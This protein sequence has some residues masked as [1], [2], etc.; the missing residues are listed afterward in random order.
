MNNNMW[1]GS[2]GW[3]STGEVST[4]SNPVFS[5]HPEPRPLTK[6]DAYPSMTMSPMCDAT[7]PK[8]IDPWGED[9]RSSDPYVKL[10]RSEGPHKLTPIAGM[11]PP[12]CDT[13]PRPPLLQG[14]EA[15]D[16]FDPQPF[17]R[18]HCRDFS[19]RQRNPL[20]QGLSRP[21][22]QSGRLPPVTH[23]PPWQASKT[24]HLKFERSVSFLSTLKEMQQRDK[25]TG[26]RMDA[27]FHGYM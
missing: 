20:R 5:Y 2:P 10:L 16:P 23:P 26:G 21:G 11:P 8:R 3:G 12:R 1:W 14:E 13:C 15:Y 18:L 25:Y 22:S 17:H 27:A 6:H 4:V 9:P 24:S 19:M 7:V